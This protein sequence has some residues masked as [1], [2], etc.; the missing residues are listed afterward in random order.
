MMFSVIPFRESGTYILSSV[1]EIQMLLD[2]HIIKT[3][4]MRGSPSVKPIEGKV[5]Y[6]K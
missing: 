1:D 2:D 3:Q 6:V 4:T 5:K